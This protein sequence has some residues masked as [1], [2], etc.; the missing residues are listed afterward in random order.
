VACYHPLMGVPIGIRPDT[1]KMQYSIRPYNE[2]AFNDEILKSSP[3]GPPVQIPCGQCIGCRLA[4]S[5]QW[6][7]RCM[8][9]LE[10]HDSAYFV[11]LTYDEAH[12]PKHYYPDPETGEAL[13]SMSLCKRDFQLFMKRL[14]KAFPDD[15]IR[16]FAAGEYG[17]KTF[18]PHYHAIIFGLHLDDLVY[19]K[20]GEGSFAYYNSPSLQK[21]WSVRQPIPVC[22]GSITPLAGQFFF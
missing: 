14:R 6:A 5:R 9:E 20:R 4:Y 19:Y 12:V 1:G 2:K 13:P 8:L 11:T 10:Y 15:K 21:C 18:R 22:E 17:T 7:N 16:F 3:M